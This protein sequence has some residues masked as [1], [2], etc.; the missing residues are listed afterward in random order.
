MPTDLARFVLGSISRANLETESCR[1]RR[2]QLSQLSERRLGIIYAGEQRACQ[3]RLGM[4]RAVVSVR[5]S[6]ILWDSFRQW[7][8]SVWFFTRRQW[9]RHYKTQHGKRNYPRPVLPSPLCSYRSACSLRDWHSIP[10][11]GLCLHDGKPHPPIGGSKASFK[12][13]VLWTLIPSARDKQDSC[14]YGP[15]ASQDGPF[16]RVSQG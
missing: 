6:K 15:L 14:H 16:R 11:K 5:Y 9:R 3:P 2:P 8:K 12:F 1:K 7:K 4:K 13:N 10:S